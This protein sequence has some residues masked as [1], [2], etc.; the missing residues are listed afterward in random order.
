M[1]LSYHCY[2]Y[3]Y[4]A[5][6]KTVTT[7]RLTYHGLPRSLLRPQTFNVLLLVN[8]TITLLLVVLLLFNKTLGTPLNVARSLSKYHV[9]LGLGKGGDEQQ[10]SFSPVC[11]VL[12][13]SVHS[14]DRLRTVDIVCPVGPCFG[15][16]IRRSY[17]VRGV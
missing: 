8:S 16:R 10:S 12:S 9:C 6:T 4:T 1:L 3:C 11:T 2:S 5:T 7:T 13:P 15:L 14:S 17:T